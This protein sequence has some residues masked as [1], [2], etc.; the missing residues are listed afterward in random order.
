MPKGVFSRFA[1]GERGGEQFAAECHDLCAPPAVSSLPITAADGCPAA[2]D[3]GIQPE[4]F[5]SW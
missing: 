2:K 4:L 3:F 1:T 5:T